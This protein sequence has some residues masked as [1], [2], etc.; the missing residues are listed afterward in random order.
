MIFFILRR[1]P[2]R[3]LSKHG[4]SCGTS[5]AQ[6]RLACSAGKDPIEVMV[7]ELEKEH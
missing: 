6:A 2:F 5:V 4:Q 3:V 7:I 1:S